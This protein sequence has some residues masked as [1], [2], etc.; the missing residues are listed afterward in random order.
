M[1]N[2]ADKVFN[3]VETNNKR[4]EAVTIEA[5]HP[6]SF[7]FLGIDNGAF[8]RED[9]GRSDAVI[10]GTVNPKTKTTTLVSL[11][12][13]SYTLMDG[14][15]MWDDSPFYD[16]LTHAYAFGGA[17]MSINSIQEF[18]NIPIDYYVEIN[19]QG[20]VDIVDALG[21]I[22]VKSPLT[23]DYMEHYFTKG[24]TRL[25]SG[26]EALA[27]SRMRKVDPQGDFGRQEREKLVIKAI[28]DKVLSLESVVNYQSILSTLEENVKT[29]LS[30]KDMKAM[31]SSYSKSLDNF[32]QDNLLGEELWLNDIYYLYVP[33]ENRLEL[34]NKLRQELEI[35][36]I[37]LEDL[38]LSDYDE[39]YM[40]DWYEEYDDNDVEEDT[41][42][43]DL[44]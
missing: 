5:T 11:P 1:N 30:Y 2:S 17:K 34:S 6:I 44:Y 35:D 26:N 25:L 39:S 15:E 27:F 21:G 9:A 12:R 3:D 36:E 28:L 43:D 8:G 37:E 4:D 40:D 23:F 13:D 18:L 7:A 24:E 19:M 22:K 29:N 31:L 16:K 14:Y 20:L 33:P 32:E 10:V 42:E 38:N 41:Y